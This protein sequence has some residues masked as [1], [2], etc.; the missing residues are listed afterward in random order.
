LTE[1]AGTEIGQRAKVIRHYAHVSADDHRDKIRILIVGGFV[2]RKGHDLLFQAVKDLGTEGDSLEVWVAGY[3]GPVDVQQLARDIGV[4]DKVRI[5]A[6]IPDQELDLLF[7]A[8]DVFCL[9]SKTVD[10]GV[11]EGLPVALIEAM[12]YAKPVIATRLAGIPELV[13]EILIDEGDIKGL[14]KALKHFIDSAE[15]RQR[16]GARN[17]EIVKARYSKRNV[18]V[19]RDLWLESLKR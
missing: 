16:S 5:F 8:C 11:N 6:G 15:V 14:T 3:Q 7:R 12:A 2:E 10:Q 17:R 9:P 4:A 1:I 18:F 13:E 19:L